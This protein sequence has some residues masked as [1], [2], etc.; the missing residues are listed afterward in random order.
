MSVIS[1]R[2]WDSLIFEPAAE[3]SEFS[4]SA[5]R[6][7]LDFS[8]QLW[9]VLPSCLFLLLSALTL[10][11]YFSVPFQYVTVKDS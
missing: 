2:N 10:S 4:H 8:Q 3:R 7:L 11:G 6:V 9:P 1:A 5:L